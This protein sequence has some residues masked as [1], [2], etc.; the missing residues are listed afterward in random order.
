[1]MWVVQVLCEQFGMRVVVLTQEC[2][3]S[4]PVVARVNGCPCDPAPTGC[5]SEPGFYVLQSSSG[6]FSGLK[7]QKGCAGSS[8]PSP[9]AAR[10]ALL[11]SVRVASADSAG[12]GVRPGPDTRSVVDIM[13]EYN[14][15]DTGDRAPNPR[16]AP[17]IDSEVSSL[18]TLSPPGSL[19]ASSMQLGTL[20]AAADRVQV[21][22]QQIDLTRQP[23]SA[24][25]GPA[26]GF[27]DALLSGRGCVADAA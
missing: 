27:L 20:L 4:T 3:G 22:V 25:P 13:R 15:R 7:R 23:A 12:S 8:A 18:R 5:M 9:D 21:G 26:A 24:V 14:E 2:T 16:T 1:M 10:S 17:E 19:R 6:N 11:T